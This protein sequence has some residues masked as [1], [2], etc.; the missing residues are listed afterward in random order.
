GAVERLN[1]RFQAQVAQIN[2]HIMHR[3]DQLDAAYQAALNHSAAQAAGHVMSPRTG[4]NG[5][6]S[7]ARINRSYDRFVRNVDRRVNKLAGRFN[8][9]VNRIG[10]RLDVMAGSSS[11]TLRADFQNTV[12]AIA[13]TLKTEAH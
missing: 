10:A 7:I 9:A 3:T 13:G 12:A 5:T 8:S 11:P 1:G 4:R 6:P 2:S